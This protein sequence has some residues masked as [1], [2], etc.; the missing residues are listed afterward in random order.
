MGEVTESEEQGTTHLQDFRRRRRSGIPRLLVN[1]VAPFSLED[2]CSSASSAE[3]GEW[4]HEEMEQSVAQCAQVNELGMTMAVPLVSVC[5]FRR[6]LQA[7]RA[8]FG[9]LQRNF[10]I[11]LPRTILRI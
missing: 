2:L 3:P 5:V 6:P 1:V 8:P 11:G 4:R 7:F 9:F 10:G